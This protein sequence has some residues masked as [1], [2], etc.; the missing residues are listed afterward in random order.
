MPPSMGGASRDISAPIMI[1]CSKR[2]GAEA[3]RP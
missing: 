2:S 1:R 3:D